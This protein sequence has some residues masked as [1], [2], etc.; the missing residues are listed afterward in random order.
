ML[1]QHIADE[2]DSGAFL[3]YQQ[4]LRVR[5]CWGGEPTI[6]ALKLCNCGGAISLRKGLQ[7]GVEIRCKTALGG[8]ACNKFRP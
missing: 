2:K 5:F 7:R 3:Q 6:E 4:G 1:H 8:K